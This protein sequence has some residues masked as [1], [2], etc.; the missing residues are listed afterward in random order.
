M[1]HLSPTSDLKS[2]PHSRPYPQP[3]PH[4][5]QPISDL[6]IGIQFAELNTVYSGRADNKSGQIAG[7][8]SST[9]THTTPQRTLVNGDAGVHVPDKKNMNTGGTDFGNLGR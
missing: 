3:G 1:S 4:P 5:N 6:D 8:Q 2:S 7:T 9:I